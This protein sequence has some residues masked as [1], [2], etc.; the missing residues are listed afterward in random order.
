MNR[1]G[2][3]LCLSGVLTAKVNIGGARLLKC[4]MAADGLITAVFALVIL[5]HM[6]MSGHARI[7][8]AAQEESTAA[9]NELVKEVK[10]LRQAVEALNTTK[11]RVRQEP[12]F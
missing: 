12:I 6:Q 8:S 4:T 2:E 7:L 9:L 1:I 3:F 10:D 5:V 11:E